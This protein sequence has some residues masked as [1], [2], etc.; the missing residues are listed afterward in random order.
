[1]KKKNKNKNNNNNN[2]KKKKKNRVVFFRTKEIK[3]LL[4]IDII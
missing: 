3:W 2:K 1:M 4:N